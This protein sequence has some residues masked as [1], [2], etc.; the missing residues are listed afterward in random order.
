VS[1]S[2]GSIAPVASISP[3]PACLATADV[4]GWD[5]AHDE[6][7]LCTKKGACVALG[8]GVAPRKSSP[9]ATPLSDVAFDLHEWSGPEQIVVAGARVQLVGAPKRWA[10]VP[11]SATKVGQLLWLSKDGTRAIV[12]RVAG[13]IGGS[14]PSRDL[15]DLVDLRE[16]TNLAHGELCNYEIH[17]GVQTNEAETAAVISFGH[18]NPIVFVGVID[19]VRAQFALLGTTSKT[20][21]EGCGV[22]DFGKKFENAEEAG[23]FD[24][25]RRR[26]GR[27]L[28]SLEGKIV[29]RLDGDF[30]SGPIA[31]GMGVERAEEIDA[32]RR[33]VVRTT[34]AGKRPVICAGV[35]RIVPATTDEGPALGPPRC[36]AQ[37][38]TSSP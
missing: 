14:K 1:S 7:T 2:S 24:A 18:D 20:G 33:V 29:A 30:P 5:E 13:A 26:A 22:D 37:C 6:I 27:T 19:L 8:A 12:L 16:H 28:V 9:P 32:N 15:V 11:F 25:T 3:P 38:P 4:V 36:I 21:Y 34:F 31:P 10:A 35:M 23:L 17:T